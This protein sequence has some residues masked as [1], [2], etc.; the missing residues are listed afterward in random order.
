MNLEDNIERIYLSAEILAAKVEEIGKQV[1]DFYAPDDEL[2]VV[3]VLNGSFCFM[4]DLVRKIKQPVTVEFFG[5][6]SYGKSTETSGNLKIT[7][8]LDHDINGKNVLIVEDIIDT[9]LTLLRMKALLSKRNPKSLRVAVLLDKPNRR[10]V[11][12]KGDFTGFEIEDYFVVGYGLDYADKY[13]NLPYIGILK[14]EA[15]ALQS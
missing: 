10:K 11:E 12:V 15:Y 7:K 1:S 5:C 13:R 3:G 4:A 8:D 2:V 14:P 6:S 9:G